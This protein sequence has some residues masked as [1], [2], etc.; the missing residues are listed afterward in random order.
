[1]L[2]PISFFEFDSRILNGGAEHGCSNDIQMPAECVHYSWDAFV[3]WLELVAASRP[4]VV[5]VV[6]EG[7][8][9]EAR[10]TV[11]VE[12]VA[13]TSVGMEHPGIAG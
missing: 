2:K 9:A 10:C 4:E 13:D 3:Q 5:R 8:I 6:L 1:M 12:P 7:C 11:L